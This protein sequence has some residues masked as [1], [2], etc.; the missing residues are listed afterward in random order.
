[1]G[2]K[3]QESQE[4]DWNSWKLAKLEYCQNIKTGE[5]DY[6]SK[7]REMYNLGSLTELQ[8]MSML[9]LS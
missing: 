8:Y 1:M 4:F 6:A 5:G 3:M 9:Y 7:L 2:Y